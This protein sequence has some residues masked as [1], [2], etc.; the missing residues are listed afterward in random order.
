MS[1]QAGMRT[2][3]RRATLRTA[4]VRRTVAAAL[5]AGA[6]GATG[7]TAQAAPQQD[8]FT[9]G[10][11][12]KTALVGGGV[13]IA[14]T[15]T[16][17]FEGPALPAGWITGN[18]AASGSVNPAGGMTISEAWARNDAPAGPGSSLRFNATFRS[19]P[20]QHVGFG[21]DYATG[22]WAIFSSSTGNGGVYARIN[23]GTGTA[24]TAPEVR[25]GDTG[26]AYDLRIDWIDTEF[27][28]YVNSVEKARFGATGMPSTV[29]SLASDFVGGTDTELKV[30]S[31]ALRTSK[32]STF[33]SRTFDAGDA[34]V[35]GI[36]F[37]PEAETLDGTSISYETQTSSD[38][39]TWSAWG[40]VGAAPPARYFRYR[41]NLSTPNAAFTPRL[42][43]ATVDFTIANTNPGGGSAPPSGDTKKPKI[44]MPRDADVNKRGKAKILLA[45][46]ADELFCKATL[47]FV[48][49]RKTIASKSGKIAGGDSRYITLKLSKAA[50]KQLAKARKMKVTA[51][52][53]VVDASGNKRTSSK[54]IW[55]YS[56]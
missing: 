4:T 13:E 2:T 23:T 19:Q 12:D 20:A 32:S 10:T 6:L 24:D 52:L 37:T 16:T 36:S 15:F 22:P 31:M 49:G 14:P 8:D 3:T 39:G 53:T 9:Q 11:H 40:P 56:L 21:V 27:V 29:K 34:R 18:W 26:T 17:A 38:N 1:H 44:G 46:P 5:I 7:G 48:S 50:K 47:K 51:T 41:A 43:K 54:K 45:C 42:K 55:L 30:S 35:T 25:V 28:F 33:T